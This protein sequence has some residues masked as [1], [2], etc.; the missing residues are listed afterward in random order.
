MKTAA[1]MKGLWA[2]LNAKQQITS[3][4]DLE[5]LLCAYFGI[6]EDIFSSDLWCQL[7][8]VECSQ[9][10]IDRFYDFCLNAVATNSSLS[11]AVL[12]MFDSVECP[13]TIPAIQRAREILYYKLVDVLNTRN[14]TAKKGITKKV[15]DNG[16]MGCMAFIITPIFAMFCPVALVGLI[17]GV[18]FLLK[19]AYG[20]I[21][22]PRTPLPELKSALKRK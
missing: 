18:F 1:T 16:C 13:Q 10:A 15:K 6:E 8:E 17:V 2:T 11:D 19:S 7:N 22:L 3:Q 14:Q 20:S 5:F 12:R 4:A 21:K 9:I